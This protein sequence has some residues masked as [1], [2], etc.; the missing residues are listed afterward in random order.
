MK[1]YK[2]NEYQPLNIF[3]YF[4][5]SFQFIHTVTL[6]F[7][8][9][10]LKYTAIGLVFNSL[11]SYPCILV[12]GFLLLLNHVTTKKEN[13]KNNKIQK[14]ITFFACFTYLAMLISF[15]TVII[16]VIYIAHGLDL[17]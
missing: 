2:T 6:L 14:L 11:E 17:Q 7:Q 3:N 4:I 13:L 9:K 5:L 16:F 1:I 12:L 15:V 10:S 8:T